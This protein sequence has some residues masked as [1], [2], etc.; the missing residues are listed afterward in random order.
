MKVAVYLS[1]VPSKSKNEFKRSLLENFAHGVKNFGDEVYLVDDV[2]AV[3]D[4]D[5]AVLQGW[6]GMKQAPHLEQRHR[7]IKRQRQAGKH[8]LIID[9][10][11]FG[12]LEPDDFNCYLRYSLDGIFPST[13]YYFDRDI[14]TT[15]WD[16]IKQFYRFEERDWRP[17]GRHVT[18][19]LQRDGGWS[20]DGVSVM[21]WLETTIPL[22]QQYTQ[23]PILIRA[24]PSSMKV[25]AEI[26]NRW[27]R[28]EISHNTDLRHDLNRSWCTVA[29][30][31]SP[32]VAS[33]LWG[34]PTFITDP[35][36][37]RSQAHG[38]A[39]TDLALL[40]NPPLPDRREFYH[41]LSQC[42]FATEHL[43]T[44]DAWRFMRA[45]MP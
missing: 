35:D 29:Y 27:P 37:H 18:L 33:I 3:A 42:H 31:S 36:P 39:C 45:R 4:A 14:D 21:D 11:L 6:I 15:R 1:A 25:L 12:F 7:V 17:D 13:G 22:V 34:V 40:G 20:M 24:H 2:N 28:L 8:T 38:F 44:G 30:N 23:R 41:R 19:C 10:N 32:G 43:V 26:E 5:I 9:S 16:E